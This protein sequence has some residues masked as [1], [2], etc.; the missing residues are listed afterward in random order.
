MDNRWPGS[1]R[2]TALIFQNLA[3]FP[4]MPVW[5]NVAFGLEM[6]GWSRRRRRDRAFE[7]LDMVALGGQGDKLPAELSGGQRQRVAIAR[8][9]A[10]EPAVLLLDEPPSALDLKLRQHMRAELKQLQV[11]TGITFVYITHN[12]GEALTMSDRVAVMPHGR[13][14][15]VGSADDIYDRPATAFVATFVGKM[16][17]LSGRIEAVARDRA[18]IATAGGSFLAQNPCGL[19]PGV[20]T[21]LFL[22]SER[23]HLLGPGEAAAN[24]LGGRLARR[25]KEGAFSTLI[26]ETPA[27][28][29]TVQ[30]V[31][32]G[33]GDLP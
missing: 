32:S 1:A 18:R 24:T 29:L 10:V 23:L 30:R 26:V 7:L 21:V 25:D 31:N 27:G 8:A 28:A 13:I 3:L 4:L 16:N 33:A 11:A 5:E 17:R 6:G 12:Q 9:L 2:P 15:Q 19:A 22:R 14:V 20:E